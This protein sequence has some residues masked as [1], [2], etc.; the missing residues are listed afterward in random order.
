MNGIST[1]AVFGTYER[2]HRDYGQLWGIIDSLNEQQR[3]AQARIKELE[4]ENALLQAKYQALHQQQFKAAVNKKKSASQATVTQSDPE[5]ASATPRKRG[6]PKGHPGWFRPR[7]ETYDHTIEV[8]APTR[9]PHCQNNALEPSDQVTEHAV[10]DIVIVQRPTTTLFRHASAFCPQCQKTVIAAA[11][12][13]PASDRI[14]PTAKSTALYL[15]HVIGISYRKTQRVMQELFGMKYAVASALTFDEQ[16]A[17]NG[18]PLYEDLREKLRATAYVHADETHWREDGQNAYVWFA[19][20]PDLAFYHIDRSRAGQVAADILGNA[21]DGTLVADGYQGYNAAN[22]ADRQ[23]CL[24]HLIRKCDAVITEIQLLETA[25]KYKDSMAF[26]AHVRTLFQEACAQAK[27]DRSAQRTPQENKTLEQ[28]LLEKLEKRCAT[29]LRHPTAEAFRKRLIGKEKN[30]WFAFLRHPGVPPTNNHAEQSI[31]PVVIMRKTS[32]G[33]RS[34]RGSQRLG[35][36][37]SLAQTAKRQHQD[38]RYFLKILL[39][40]DTAAAQRALYRNT[41]DP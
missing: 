15:R 8:P 6:A 27:P 40:H 11:P 19:G 20:N 23:S 4:K 13:Q 17:H 5:Q 14:G 18:E 30:Q 12:G 32:F 10:E 41:G 3:Q 31:R 26:C 39:T 33:T 22:P 2:Y 37:L 38:I 29:P 1:R 7:P 36:L 34:P 21:Y 35:I 25:E 28:A 9:C 16:A 24:S